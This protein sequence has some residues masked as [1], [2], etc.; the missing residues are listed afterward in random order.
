MALRWHTVVVDCS[1]LRAQA[2]WW[3]EALD[4]HL[5]HEADTDCVIVP[6]W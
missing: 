1:D 3:A 2:R 5:I 6:S 4:W